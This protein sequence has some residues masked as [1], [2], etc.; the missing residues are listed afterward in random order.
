M[1]D[2][3]VMKSAS[4]CLVVTRFLPTTHVGSVDAPLVLLDHLQIDRVEQRQ[5]LAA[6][7]SVMI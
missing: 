2:F 7:A 6:S 4:A 3:F 1:V 5:I